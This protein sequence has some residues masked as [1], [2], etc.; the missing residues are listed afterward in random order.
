MQWG[1]RASPLSWHQCRAVSSTQPLPE[2][3]WAP[4]AHCNS[5]QRE[6]TRGIQLIPMVPVN[7]ALW[8]ALFLE[9]RSHLPAPSPA[10]TTICITVVA[11]NLVSEP[12]AALGSCAATAIG[13]L[14]EIQLTKPGFLDLFQP[15][16]CTCTGHT[17]CPKW[18]RRSGR[19]SSQG[20]VL[21]C[22]HKIRQHQSFGEMHPNL[23]K[24]CCFLKAKYCSV[25]PV[26]CSSLFMGQRT[27]LEHPLLLHQRK[28][29]AAW[30]GQFRCP[31]PPSEPKWRSLPTLILSV[32]HP[33]MQGG[34]DAV[35]FCSAHSQS[36]VIFSSVSPLFAHLF[37]RIWEGGRFQELTKDRLCP[38]PGYVPPAWLAAA[39]KVVT[40]P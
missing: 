25:C 26:G 28:R 21:L 8:L 30:R 27:P 32:P 38:S 40:A 18:A 7:T 10:F 31:Q 11:E 20:D 4:V 15:L 6:V 33:S 1:Q 16:L 17:N 2:H 22:T 14:G 34:K 12:M 36:N 9:L 35:S 23:V 3:P 13:L 37:S 39:E 24:A 19:I 5:L 29:M